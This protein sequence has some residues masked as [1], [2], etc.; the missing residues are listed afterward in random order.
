MAV[1]IKGIDQDSTINTRSNTPHGTYHLAD[2]AN[3]YEPQ[4]SNNFE[5]V[6][7][8]I[9]NMDRA[10]GQHGPLPDGS[11]HQEVLRMAVSSAFVPHY[12]TNVLKIERGNSTLKFAGKPTFDSGEIQFNDYVGANIAEILLAWRGQVNN[13]ETEKTGLIED[14]KRK[15][16]LEEYTADWQLVRRYVLYGCWPS[17]LKEDNFDYTNDDQRKISMTLE[18]DKAF[19]D[20]SEESVY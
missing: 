20:Y 19:L 16:Y 3:Y 17:A 2:N 18:Y 1:R 4:R 10:G 5:F 7:M 11:M 12:S 14:Y 15:C 6:I 8:D 9:N 13:I